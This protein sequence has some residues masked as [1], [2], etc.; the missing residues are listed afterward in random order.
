MSDPASSSVYKQQRRRI[1]SH[2]LL[3]RHHVKLAI[4][5]LVGLALAH[6][7][8]QRFR[9]SDAAPTS[10][11]SHWRNRPQK[12]QPTTL[13]DG[14]STSMIVRICLLMPE[15]ITNRREDHLYLTMRC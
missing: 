7:I 3:N 6:F 12:T 8:G 9:P 4:R 14:K 5:I 2:V 11:K 10:P 15:V 1:I 13:A